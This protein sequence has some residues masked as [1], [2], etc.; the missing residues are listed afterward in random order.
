MLETERLVLRPF[1]EGDLDAMCAVYRD[2]E[3]VHHPGGGRQR[4]REDLAERLTRVLTHWELHGFGLF[5]LVDREKRDFLGHC[6][7]A[8]LHGMDD[9]ELS[10]ALALHAWGRG[11][12]TEAVRQVLRHAFEVVGLPRVVGVALAAN[13]ASQRVMTRAGM[14]VRQPYV[15]DGKDAV[16]FAIDNPMSPSVG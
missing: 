1:E 4:S 12:A 6:G 16:L 13:V 14:T 7:V 10:F 3:F 9:A 8:Y 11:L 2:P 15:I 5:A